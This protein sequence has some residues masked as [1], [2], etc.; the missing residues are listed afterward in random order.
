VGEVEIE[1]GFGQAR[2][3]VAVDAVLL[4]AGRMA[5]HAV[6]EMALAGQHA[7]HCV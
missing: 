5:G 7:G 6:A 2:A 4:A 3:E 1:V